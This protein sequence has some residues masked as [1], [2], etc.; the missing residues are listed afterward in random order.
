MTR[1]LSLIALA[2]ILLSPAMAADSAGFIA[3]PLFGDIHFDEGGMDADFLIGPYVKSIA[4][5]D[6]NRADAHCLAEP[7]QRHPKTHGY[8]QPGGGGGHG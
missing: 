2:V 1:L 7:E 4:R 8:L 3:L 5:F 6:R